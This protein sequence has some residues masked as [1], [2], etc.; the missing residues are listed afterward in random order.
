MLMNQ[1]F[2]TGLSGTD[3]RSINVHVK[4]CNGATLQ[5]GLARLPL[6]AL[7]ATEIS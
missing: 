3:L 4:T 1:L 2:H 5:R 6:F 7:I